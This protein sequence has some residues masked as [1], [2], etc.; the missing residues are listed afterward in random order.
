MCIPRSADKPPVDLSA[1]RQNTGAI[2]GKILGRTGYLC[3]ALALVLSLGACGKTTP[4]PAAPAGKQGA[5]Y[6]IGFVVAIT[7]ASSS[8]GEPER[9]VAVMVQKQLDA[10]GGI[11]GPDGVRHPVKIIIQDTESKGD[12]AVPVAKKLINDEG[13]VA[14]IGPTTSQE[15]M[16]LIPVVQEAQVTMISLASSS[17]I[18]KPV[19]E[20]KWIF[21]VAQSNEHT[22]P[23]QVKYAKAKGLTKVANIYVNNAYGEDGALAIRETAKAEGVEIVLEETF[24]AADTDMTAQITKIK[25]SGAQAV[26]VTAIPPA[27]A[28]FTKQYRELGLTLP[29]L[30]NSGVGMQSFIDLAGAANVE[31]VIFPIGKVVAV[32]ALADTDPQKPVLQRFVADYKAATGKYPNQFAAH[33]WDALQIVLQVLQTFPDGLPL[34]EQ[35]ARLRDG[36]E[37]LK[38]FVG[39]D[40][41]FNFSPQDHVGLSLNDVVL[42]RIT[43]GQ[44][45]YFPPDQW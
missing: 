36:I 2:M 31:G 17:A 28:I 29:L 20:R 19:A 35:R 22:A 10:Q 41:V 24:D 1:P 42:V 3:L 11:V 27:A 9:D 26:L 30:H 5:A 34:T 15:S 37:N 40:G 13:V 12:V 33:A 21:K 45:R 4:T 14:L 18:V 39:A 6:K 7:G 25:A 44:W 16:A 43:G 8:L 23:W 32:D 38:G